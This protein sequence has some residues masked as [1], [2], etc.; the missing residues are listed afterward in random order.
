MQTVLAYK[1]LCMSLTIKW[2]MAMKVRHRKMHQYLKKCQR[3]ELDIERF[4]QSMAW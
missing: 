4:K 2:R 3:P 1:V